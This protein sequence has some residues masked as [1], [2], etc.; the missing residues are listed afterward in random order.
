MA[1]F[2]TNIWIEYYARELTEVTFEANSQ[3]EAD[4]MVADDDIDVVDYIDT[5]DY[6]TGDATGYTEV[7]EDATAE[8][9][10]GSLPQPPLLRRKSK[11]N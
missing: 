2:R 3:A 10:E 1:L 11:S 9:V 8:Y 6:Y 7:D 4:A 5:I